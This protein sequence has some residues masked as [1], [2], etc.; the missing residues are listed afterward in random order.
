MR[1][2]ILRSQNCIE[3]V[4]LVFFFLFFLYFDLFEL[5]W[6]LLVI[7]LCCAAFSMNATKS[8]LSF[9]YVYCH[10]QLI[11][12]LRLHRLFFHRQSQ[13]LL[14]LIFI[15]VVA[16]EVV[17]RLN[18]FTKHLNTNGDKDQLT[19][20]IPCFCRKVQRTIQCLKR[21]FALNVAFK[22]QLSQYLDLQGILQNDLKKWW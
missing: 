19:L 20:T 4:L 21:I 15:I 9:S 11:A 7:W 14:L 10:Q 16:E 12:H 1:I 17:Q 6:N 3:C 5:N 13:F 18:Q 2:R 8:N 22:L